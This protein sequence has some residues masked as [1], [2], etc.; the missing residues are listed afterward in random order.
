[1]SGPVQEDKYLLQNSGNTS[2][3][4][5]FYTFPF[6]MT[7]T[8]CKPAEIRLFCQIL[9]LSIFYQQIYHFSTKSYVF[10]NKFIIF[11]K[12]INFYGPIWAPT[13]TWAPTRPWEEYFISWRQPVVSK[14]TILRFSKQ[15]LGSP[16]NS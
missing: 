6:F 10:I 7:S 16:N 11:Y 15:V 5:R 3:F 12:N 14:Q 4:L 9:H 13:R 2:F 8:Y 1:M